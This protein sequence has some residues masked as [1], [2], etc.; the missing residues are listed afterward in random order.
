MVDSLLDDYIYFVFVFYDSVNS[1]KLS[2]EELE[3]IRE[4]NPKTSFIYVFQA[5][6]DGNFKGA[7]EYSHDVDV[8]IELKD[9]VAYT[10]K[11]RFGGNGEMK[12]F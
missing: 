3:E 9:G 10:E 12:V 1:L 5:T 6:K 4:N 8:L 11:S 2:P 7:Q